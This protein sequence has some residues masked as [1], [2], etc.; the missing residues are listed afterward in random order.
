MI[1]E[2]IGR[3]APETIEWLA[4]YRVYGL[5]RIPARGDRIGARLDRASARG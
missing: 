2:D 4:E 3:R 5:A 1:I